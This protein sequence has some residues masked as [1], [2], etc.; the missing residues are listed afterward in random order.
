MST[1]S[2]AIQLRLKLPQRIVAKSE[3]LDYPR[4]GVDVAFS[5]NFDFAGCVNVTHRAPNQFS[6]RFGRKVAPIDEF[7]G[8]AFDKRA[9]GNDKADLS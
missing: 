1:P 9:G 4:H 2:Y 5:E 3:V 6:Y 8:N 7:V